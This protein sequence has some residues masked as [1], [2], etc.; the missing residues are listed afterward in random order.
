M[1]G[2]SIQVSAAV[3]SALAAGEPVVALESAVITHGLPRTPT[4]H[5]PESLKPHWSNESPA[6]LELARQ[7]QRVVREE[8]ATPATIAVINGVLTIGLED[9]QLT[10]LAADANAVKVSSRD[11]APAMATKVN[12]GTTVAATLIGCT[13]AT[14]QPIR[15]FATGG[16]G[17]VHRNWM[18]QPDISNDLTQ[19]AREQV[20]VVCAGAKSILDIP[21]TLEAL[22][23]LGVPVI[24][25]RTDHFPRFVCPPDP[26][27]LLAHHVETEAELAPL[28]HLHW[29]D[30]GQTSAVVAAQAVDPS[31]AVDPTVYADAVQEAEWEADRA[32][33]RGAMRT[34]FLLDQIARLT[35]GAALR[36]NLDLLV[37]NART[38]ARTAMALAARDD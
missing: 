26:D 23:T 5:L 33:A 11:L 14:P 25:L 10:R 1:A 37:A 12:A 3:R 15:V 17:G 32:A 35:R 34:P 28:C 27:Q 8:G 16:I 4:D 30:L 13:R 29:N 24:G 18:N 2:E 31:V 7:M 38:A 19:L 20:C 21:A 6:N 9:D 22:E 36:A